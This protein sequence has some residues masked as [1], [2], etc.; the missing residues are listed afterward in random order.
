SA[1]SCFIADTM[2]NGLVRAL[3]RSRITS[4]GVVFRISVSAD[5]LERGKTTGT[6]SRL[7]VVLILDENIKSSSTATI[8]GFMILESQ[9]VGPF[10]KNGFVVGCETTR[11]AVLIDPGDEVAALLAFAERHTLAIRHILLTHAHV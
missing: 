10:F 9:A 4:V 7:A 8:M 3:L 5:S 2:P 6:P 11:E 1:A